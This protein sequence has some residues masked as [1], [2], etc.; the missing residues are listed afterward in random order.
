M[1]AGDLSGLQRDFAQRGR[2]LSALQFLPEVAGAGA[3][4]ED[5]VEV[6]QA[7]VCPQ[8]FANIEVG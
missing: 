8:M 7:D 6:L 5:E 2:Q 4:L 3:G 1:Q